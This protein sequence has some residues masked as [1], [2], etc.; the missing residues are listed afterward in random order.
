MLE[1]SADEFEVA[2]QQEAL[3]TLS[4]VKDVQKLLEPQKHP[5]FDDEHC[6]DCHADMPQ[7]RLTDGR[8]RCTACETEIEE[9][10]KGFRPQR[11]KS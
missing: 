11:R 2:S 1:K 7:Q 3:R 10:A 4:S 9:K 8:I 6:L 5:D